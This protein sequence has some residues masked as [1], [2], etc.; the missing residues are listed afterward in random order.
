[1]SG[2]RSIFRRRVVAGAP[3]GILPYY[4]VA[5]MR[6]VASKTGA[7]ILSLSNRG[8]T[9]NRLNPSFFLDAEGTDTMYYAY[10]VSYGQATFTDLGAQLQGGWDGA[11]SDF[12][13]TLGPIIV[14]VTIDGTPVPFYLYQTD[15]NNVGP[16]SWS[17]T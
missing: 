8:P 17:V 5:T 6:S 11:H 16:V 1:M 14:S 9:A 3:A 10:P 13:V 4:G 2:L 15:Y 7:F 12:G